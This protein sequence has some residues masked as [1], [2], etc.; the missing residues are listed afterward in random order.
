M[1]TVD[2]NASSTQNLLFARYH[3]SEA[4][5]ARWLLVS[6]I[7]IGKEVL[8]CISITHLQSYIDKPKP[9]FYF[10]KHW[11]ANTFPRT[12]KSSL[13]DHVIPILV[14][15]FGDQLIAP[16]ISVAYGLKLGTIVPMGFNLV[17]R[18]SFF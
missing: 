5:L 12:P 7:L 13:D 4:C 11:P 15:G 8:C 2:E 3:L 16:A 9:L 17:P 10:A 1:E 14:V 18:L 6:K